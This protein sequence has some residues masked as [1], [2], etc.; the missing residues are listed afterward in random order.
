MW[1]ALIPVKCPKLLGGKH[2]RDRMGLYCLYLLFFCKNYSFYPLFLSN[3]I[4][5]NLVFS[6]Y[7]LSFLNQLFRARGEEL[8][9]LSVCL[10]NEF[11]SW[12][13]NFESFGCPI[14]SQAIFDHKLNELLFFLSNIESYLGSYDSMVF[15]QLLIVIVFL[16][17]SNFSH[18]YNYKLQ[19]SKHYN[20]YPDLTFTLFIRVQEGR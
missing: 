13:T 2:I 16:I 15:L 6:I 11:S 3:I 4:L 7:L 10:Y 5:E 8:I 14:D 12:M 20:S 1:H 9:A 18:Y 19:I 17:G